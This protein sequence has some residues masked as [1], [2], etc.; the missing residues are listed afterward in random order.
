MNR[1]RVIIAIILLLIGITTIIIGF[2]YQNKE[3]NTSVDN[4]NIINDEIIPNS[5]VNI[6]LNNFNIEKLDN[7]VNIKFNLENYGDTT[8]KNQ[9]IN[10]NFYDDNLLYRY[11]YIIENLES[12]NALAISDKL[13]FNYKE[14]S[15]YEFEV[16]NQKTEII[17]TI[18]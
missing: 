4:F 8:I 18:K 13:I 11:E 10:I 17:P 9:K 14:I 5:N 16:N 15:R 3:K 12:Y 1:K 6:N 7:E 2:S